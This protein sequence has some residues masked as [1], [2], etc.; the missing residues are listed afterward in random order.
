MTSEP[1]TDITESAGK[2]RGSGRLSRCFCFGGADDTCSNRTGAE[3]IGFAKG[4]ADAETGANT[5]TGKDAGSC[6]GNSGPDGNHAE[7]RKNLNN[8]GTSKF[9]KTVCFRSNAKKG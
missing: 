1:G 9:K 7:K 5:K 6:A 8:T 3:C 2:N 4:G